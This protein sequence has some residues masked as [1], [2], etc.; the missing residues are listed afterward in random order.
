MFKYLNKYRYLGM[1][2]LPREVFIKNSSINME[3]LNIRTGETAAGA[4]FVSITEIVSD[5]QKIG[6]GAWLIINNYILDVLWGNHCFFLFG[7]HSKDEI[8]R[9]SAT[10]TTVLLKFDSLRSLENYIK[11]VYYSNYPMT[12]YFQV[13]FLKIKCTDNADSAI[14]NEL[15]SERK[16]SILTEISPRT[17]KKM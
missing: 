14:K 8:G 2:D 1:E 9:M 10:G 5:C 3:V 16:K 15:K 12:L 13:Q 17:R 4:Y 11:S 6:T 7:S